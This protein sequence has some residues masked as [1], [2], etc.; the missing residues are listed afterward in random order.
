MLADLAVSVD[1]ALLRRIVRLRID[2]GELPR[3]LGNDRLWAGKGAGRNCSACDQPIPP[4][5]NE[6]E[7]VMDKDVSIGGSLLF[8]RGCLDVWIAE[9]Q[10][11][12]D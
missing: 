12:D 5:D 10:R 6:Y 11:G 1:T 9:C 7:V 3:G 4:T 8:H 2:S